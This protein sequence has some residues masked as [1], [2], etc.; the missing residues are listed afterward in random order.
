MRFDEF[1]FSKETQKAIAKLG[2]EEPTPIQM[3]AIPVIMK[4][5]DVIGQ[6][7]TGTGK[8]ASFGIPM[9]EMYQK[10]K[11]PFALVLEPTR[12]LAVQVSEEIANIALYK[13][14]N[15]LPVYGGKSID[16][17]IRAF[18][19]GVDIVIGTP[20]RIMDHINRKTLSLVDIKIVVVDEADEMLDMGF[21][22]DIET[23]LNET[24]S[25]R[26]TLLFSATMPEAIVT[27]SKKYMKKPEKIRVNPGGIIVPKIKQVFYEVRNEDKINALA[28][29]LDVED[30]SLA[31]VFCHTKKDVD[32]V[33]RKLQHMGY[34]ADALHGDYSQARREEVMGKFRNGQIEILV[35][36]DVAARGLDI[37][38]VS[39]VFNFSIPQSPDNYI[40]RIGRTGRAGKSGIAITL[41]TPREYTYLRQIEKKAQTVIDR[42]KLPS[43]KEAIKALARNIEGSIAE[44]I[45]QN[46]HAGYLELANT[47]SDKFSTADMSAALMFAAFGDLPE[48]IPELERA[49][50]KDKDRDRDRDR[51]KDRDR[52]RDRQRGGH[53]PSTGNR[54]LFMT[55]GKM[56][57]INVQDIVNSIA[58]ETG[59]P[60]R[61]IS[62][63]MMLEKFTF[64]EVPEDVADRV[65]RKINDMVLKGRK[66]KIAEAR[67]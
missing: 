43:H 23:I 8:T 18:K 50:F 41:V 65:I 27:I 59:I 15:I 56:D 33:A 28:R 12:E 30:P 9:V 55:I 60:Q 35:A 5:V 57:K 1:A 13:K 36:T 6:A 26:Q 63:V 49:R 37:Q 21:I 34:N 48:D 47:L 42:K 14:L 24:P 54:R 11:R 29:L 39:H 25:E 31:I 58:A 10:S 53:E 61:K 51:H 2:F 45:E 3:S 7:Q 52:D 4:G 40:H 32:D 46:K 16:T 44:I 20:G 67:K 19:R 17:Q 62:N 66:V 38:N 64:L 22:E